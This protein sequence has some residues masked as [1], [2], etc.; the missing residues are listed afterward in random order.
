M[1]EIACDDPRRQQYVSRSRPTA[2]STKAKVVFGIIGPTKADRDRR[3]RRS[4]W[5]QG[6]TSGALHRRFHYE[7]WHSRPRRASDLPEHDRELDPEWG[8][9]AFV[10]RGA[11]IT[12]ASPP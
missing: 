10:L 1:Q 11:W 6:G 9:E 5:L 8:G 12:K 3:H 7:H 4:S 2:R